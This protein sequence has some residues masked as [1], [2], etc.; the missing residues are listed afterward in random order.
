MK[1]HKDITNQR[2]G[3]L[4][5]KEYIKDSK[6][7]C[8]CDCTN[9]HIAS[10]SDL[11]AGK[12]QSCG[13]LKYDNLPY[14]KK[15]D[16]R[17]YHI[18][19]AMLD[20]CYKESCRAYKNYGGRGIIVCD[21]WKNDFLKFEEW[22]LLS[23][24][25]SNLTIDRILVNENYC[26]DNCKWSTKEQQ[27]D[28]RRNTRY[29]TINNVTKTFSQWCRDCNLD[30]STLESRL[31]MGWTGEDLIR[32]IDKIYYSQEKVKIKNEEL[33]LKEISEKYNIPYSI[34]R[35]RYT[36]GAKDESII[37][38]VQKRNYN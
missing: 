11:E 5:A 28:N 32:P 14:K 10:L 21:E 24:Y 6:W 13:C 35:K 38:P 25:K 4:V 2:F 3:K 1:S 37:K 30:K 36:R 22:A 12:V 15:V 8:E 33:T 16:D 31:K 17:L 23:G 26:P 27:N 29:L 7:L 18:W 20:R 9:T 19:Y 34:I